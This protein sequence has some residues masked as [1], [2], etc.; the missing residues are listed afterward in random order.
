MVEERKMFRI[1][2]FALIFVVI[3]VIVIKASN[4]SDKID[5]DKGTEG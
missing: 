2:Y 4:L 5:R 1:I 3:M